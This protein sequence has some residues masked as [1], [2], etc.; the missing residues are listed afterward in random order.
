MP[1]DRPLNICIT[2]G[3]AGFGESL[4]RDFLLLGHNVVSC[5]RSP[6]PKEFLENKSFS[7]IK[8]DLTKHEDCDAFIKFSVDKLGVIDAFILNAGFGGD[9]IDKKFGDVSKEDVMSI[10]ETNLTCVVYLTHQI[11]P[12][13]SK[14]KNG[15]HVVFV[16]GLG[17]DGRKQDGFTA[18][19]TTKYALTYFQDALALEYTDSNVGFHNIYPGMLVTSQPFERLGRL[20]WVANVLGETPGN[21]ARYFV[22]KVC[23]LSG[24][25]TNLSYLSG[26]S[27]AL[28][29]LISGIYRQNLV[30]EK[31]GKILCD[32]K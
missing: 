2:G 13:L 14:Q 21:T 3:S 1:R 16:Q 18:I 8:C 4:V 6:P 12:I 24:T 28:R 25:G 20:S 10:I 9:S 22:P 19:G 5:S 31:T 30:D 15:G 27:V 17:R 26:P 29:F 7:W 23:K 11:L 32:T